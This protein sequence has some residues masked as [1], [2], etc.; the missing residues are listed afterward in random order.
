MTM[1]YCS[2]CQKNVDAKIKIGIGSL[3][4]IIFTG[5]FWLLALPFYSKRCSICENSHVEPPKSDS[6]IRRINQANHAPTQVVHTS[7]P[8]TQLEK[9]AKLKDSGA[10]TE[11]EYQIQ[12]SRLLG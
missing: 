8:I 7:D 12:K 11:E 10:I 4:A 2:V 3:I 9:L 1:K 6:E 5:L